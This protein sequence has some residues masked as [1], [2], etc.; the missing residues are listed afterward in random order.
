MQDDQ[1]IQVA[2][3]KDKLKILK[4]GAVASILDG[5]EQSRLFVCDKV[6]VVRNTEGQGPVAFKQRFIPVVCT[7]EMQGVE[8]SSGHD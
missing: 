6:G 5:I 4:V 3:V 1:V 8:D 7:Y 2:S